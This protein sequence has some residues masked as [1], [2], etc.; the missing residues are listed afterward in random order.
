MHSVGVVELVRA[1]G[2]TVQLL[3]VEPTWKLILGLIDV[4]DG[5]DTGGIIKLFHDISTSYMS[6][7]LNPIKIRGHQIEYREEIDIPN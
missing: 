7:M 2:N 6:L 5:D 1:L 3:D 4:S